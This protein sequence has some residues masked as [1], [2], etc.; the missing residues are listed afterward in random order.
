MPITAAVVDENAG[1]KSLDEI[2]AYFVSI[3]EKFST[4]KE[5]S[6]IS[7]INRGEIGPEK[8][9]DDMKIVFELSE[10]TKIETGGY[11][12]ILT[13]EKIYDPSGL[14]KGWSIFNA[15]EMLSK[16]G[17]KNFFVE[18]G[19][20]IE[21]RGKNAKGKKWSVG[22]RDP[23][24]ADKSKIVK[25]IY[26]TD[27]GLATSGTAERGQHIYN[28]LAGRQTLRD[29]V[30]I[31]VIGRNVYEADRLATAAFAMGKEGINFIEGLEGF[32]GYSID[33]KGLATMTSGFE[34][35]LKI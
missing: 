16:F 9:S 33:S 17:Y 8:W 28:P 32:E 22:I 7:R 26:I 30:S 19:G 35:F 21:A 11:F 25:T 10:K 20:D 5:N 2:F 6:E 34:K 12:D 31:T 24:D 27:G 29:I 3:D 13:P 1:Q 4:Y 14:V 23:F 18:A 15:A